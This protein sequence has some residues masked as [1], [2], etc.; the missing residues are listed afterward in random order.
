MIP[1]VSRSPTPSDLNS[2]ADQSPQVLIAAAERI[3]HDDPLPPIAL[4]PV[5]LAAARAGTRDECTDMTVNVVAAGAAMTC[6]VVIGGLPGIAVGVGVGVAA[7]V[8]VRLY[9]FCSA[10][11]E[12]P[13]Q[14]APDQAGLDEV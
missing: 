12:D 11:G 14:A 7:H 8:G 3:I 10:Q 6:A 5:A 4:H 2:Q 9:N 13:P 1:P